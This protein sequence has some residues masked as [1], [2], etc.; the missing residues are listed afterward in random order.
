MHKKGKSMA[1]NS[2]GEFFIKL[3]VNYDDKNAKA[4]QKSMKKT[5]EAVGSTAKGFGVLATQSK[6]ATSTI[7]NNLGT[8]S[9]IAK[10][11]TFTIAGLGTGAVYAGAKIGKSLINLQNLSQQTGSS[12][13]DIEL[14]RRQLEQVGGSANDADGFVRGFA[15]RIAQL[16]VLGGDAGVFLPQI[17]KDGGNLNDPVKALERVREFLLK[18]G[19]D[20]RLLVAQDLGLSPE[21]LSLLTAPQQEFESIR[22]KALSTQIADA[23]YIKKA[24][25]F[26]SDFSALQSEF[27]RIKLDLFAGTSKDIQ[28]V[29]KELKEF[30]SEEDIKTIII[31]SV[32]KISQLFQ[33]MIKGFGGVLERVSVA[34]QQLSS[35][36]TLGAVKTLASGTEEQR[37]AK[38]LKKNKSL[39]NKD[40]T[41]RL[42][43]SSINSVG[44]KAVS[45]E[46]ER[47]GISGGDINLPASIQRLTGLSASEKEV[48][49]AV[50]NRQATNNVNITQ[51]FNNSTTT[52]DEAGAL[53]RSLQQA[54]ATFNTKEYN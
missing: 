9:S 42:N 23:S 6:Q 14:F 53:K 31:E 1:S 25:D 33:L 47:R 38:Q 28:E 45:D 13:Q 12:V 4:F 48:Q 18:Q 10:K 44:F 16:K 37:I 50:N 32:K 27:R 41:R 8:I 3:G 40:L 52:A 34:G 36:N 22:K 26:Q 15:E 43:L 7:R 2:I 5:D 19:K 21:L 51:N 29:V 39:S 11:A 46:F 17:F 54:S 24:K 49:Q 30:L 35:G 20:K